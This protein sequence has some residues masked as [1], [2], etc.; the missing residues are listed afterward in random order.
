MATTF[1][2][3]ASVTVGSGGASSIAFTSIPSTYTDL[4]IKMSARTLGAA[5]P[6]F[7]EM[8]IN[9]SLANFTSRRIQGNGSA[10]SSSNFTNPYSNI[11]TNDQT[12]KTFCSVEIYIPNYAGSN[13]KSVSVD[14]ITE[15]NATAAAAGLWAWLWSQTAAVSSL[16]FTSSA[17]FMQYSTAT[18][19]GIK[20]S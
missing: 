16:T 11:E 19:Y 8:A 17:N 3:I 9:G 2:K 20:N 18:L 10:A 5:S 15:N 1:T 14:S 6:D 4:V 13:F 7:T 12:A